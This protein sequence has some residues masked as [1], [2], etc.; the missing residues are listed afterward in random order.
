MDCALTVQK[1][2]TAV[3]KS[4]KCAKRVFMIVSSDLRTNGSVELRY[5]I[6]CEFF[7]IFKKKESDDGTYTSLL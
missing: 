6:P 1:I 4:S 2:S 7:I 3:G 5:G